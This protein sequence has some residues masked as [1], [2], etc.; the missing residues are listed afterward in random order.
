[1][2][3]KRALPLRFYQTIHQN[4]YRKRKVFALF[5]V[6]LI[7]ALC[8]SCIFG[9]LSI[10]HGINRL[11]CVSYYIT[12]PYTQPTYYIT[13]GR[14]VQDSHYLVEI[15]RSHPLATGF[16]SRNMIDLHV[17]LA[18]PHICNP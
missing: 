10:H 6:F 17:P 9:T 7:G 5:L 13:V 4:R 2:V 18:K 1:M 3:S 12:N 15:G 8:F 14:P 16:E 11:P